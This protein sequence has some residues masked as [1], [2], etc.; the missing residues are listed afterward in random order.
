MAIQNTGGRD[1]AVDSGL[2]LG[3]GAKL[4]AGSIVSMREC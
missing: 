2:R 3:D 1:G 4:D